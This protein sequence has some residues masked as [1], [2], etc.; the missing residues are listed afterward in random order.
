ME[1]V[2]KGK[3]NPEGLQ[4]IKKEIIA[5]NAVYFGDSVDD[6]KAARNAG[7]EGIGILPPKCK[8]KKLEKLLKQNGAAKVFGN[9]NEALEDFI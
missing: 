4:R 5:K 6:M 1:D 3:P 7:V 2:E 8:E 9:I